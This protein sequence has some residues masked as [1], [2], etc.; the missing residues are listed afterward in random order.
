MNVWRRCRRLWHEQY[1]LNH[2]PTE[3]AQPLSFGIAY[4]TGIEKLMYCWKE[5]KQDVYLGNA[6]AAFEY[7]YSLGKNKGPTDR[8]DYWL[9]IGGTLI[10]N[11]A[12][13]LRQKGFEPLSIEKKCQR[14]GFSGRIDC[15]GKIGDR[16]ILVDWKTAGRQFT[17][18]RVDEDEQLTAYGWM[19]PGE[20]DRVAFC[21][22][23]KSTCMVYWYES[24]RTKQQLQEFAEQVKIVRRE[25]EEAEKFPGKH[26]KRACM[27]YNHKCDMWCDGHCEGLD[28]F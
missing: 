25:I 14:P 11:T 23:I 16:R 9:K 19:L 17:Q 6:I 18:K 8:L 15:L 28:S 2:W 13:L 27:A 3:K 21:V 26:T 4:H 1:R 20:W 7:E 22:G 5:D 10:T 24:T 12:K